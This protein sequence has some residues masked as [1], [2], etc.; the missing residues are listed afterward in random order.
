M[1]TLRDDLPTPALI[2]E[3]AALA[4]NIAAMADYARSAGVALR[5]HA[6]THKSADIA[7]LQLAEG[8][9][10][11]CCAKLGEAEALAAEGVDGLLI[12]SP[13][14]P[15]Q[16]VARLAALNRR[17]ADLSVVVDHPANAD[18]LAHAAQDKPLAVLIDIDPGMHRTGVTSPAAAVELAQRIAGSGALVYRGVQF[19]CGMQQH[20]ASFAE[21]RAAIVERTAY[22]ETVLAALADAG[23]AAPSV[24]GG[25]TG[26]F[27][28]DVEQG[29]LSELQVG[30]YIFLD[31][32]YGDCEFATAPKFLPAL[33]IDTRVVSAN[34]PGMVTLDAGLKAMA[35]EAGPAVVLAGAD[36]ASRFAFMGDEHG[37]LV[38]PSGGSD[39]AYGARITLQPPH[40]DPTVNLY[41]RYAV[42]EGE[43]VIGFWSVTARG[44]SG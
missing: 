15:P 4:A 25:G 19:Y 41:D 37:C 13:V 5:P 29:V 23:F 44:R 18:A 24:S 10:G 9:V 42:C 38:T 43:Q 17:T 33:A 34:T 27:A 20:V 7:R 3:R 26:S 39:P 31:R 12:T 16:A 14:V 21:R 2:I 28:I 36:P 32:Q 30:S 6:K 8:A 40:C 1:T 35:T 22:L 11:V